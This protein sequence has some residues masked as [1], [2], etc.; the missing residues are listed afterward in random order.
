MVQWLRHHASTAGGLRL[1]PGRGTEIPHDPLH[2]QKIL[3]WRICL[4]AY[5]N[6]ILH[7]FTLH[8]AFFC[9]ITE[10]VT[11]S[12]VLYFFPYRTDP[13]LLSYLHQKQADCFL[14]TPSPT[15]PWWWRI[16]ESL[17]VKPLP[18]DLDFFSY[19]WTYLQ[20]RNRDG[21]GENEPVDTERRGEG[22]IDW[23]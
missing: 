3:K 18:Q 16:P 13:N 11:T 1:I 8:T 14:S 9:P 19:R 10:A 23:G 2:G 20:G 15:L 12:R 21:D 17:Y 7:F 6:I 22:G 4:F 5:L